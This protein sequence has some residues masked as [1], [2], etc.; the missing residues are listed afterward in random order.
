MIALPDM[1][2][3]FWAFCRLTNHSE[4]QSMPTSRTSSRKFFFQ[5]S[6]PFINS[7]CMVR[8]SKAVF[9]ADWNCEMLS[10]DDHQQCCRVRSAAP[11]GPHGCSAGHSGSENL[12]RQQ[13]C[14]QTGEHPQQCLHGPVIHASHSGS[15]DLQ[16]TAALWSSR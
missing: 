11:R 5:A 3:H 2:A 9:P 15:E 14:G 16:E 8:A 10:G 12:W 7:R 4:A 6:A 13:S 1:H